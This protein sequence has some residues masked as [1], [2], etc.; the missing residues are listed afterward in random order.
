MIFDF[1]NYTFSGLLSILASLYGVGYPLIM[2]SIGRIYTQYDSTLL[3]NR[4]TKETI[5][6]VFQVLLILNLLFAVST[7]FLLHA[8]WWNIGFVTIQA[9]LLVL[10]MGFTFL[11]FQLMIKYENAGELLRHIEGGQIDKSNIMDIFDLAIY[12]DSKNNHQL[13]ID[14]MSSVFSYITVQQG[15]D[16]KKQNDNEILPPV[17][18]DENVVAILK[19]IKGFIREDD[20]H[21]LL[22]RNNDIVSVLYNQLSKSRISLQAH[23]MMW[24]LLNEA[25][26]YNN[27]SWFKQYW[28]FANSYSSLRYRFVT[29]PILSQDKKEF[30]LRHVMIGTLLL[31]NERYK[32][33]NDIFLY[34]HSEPEYYGLIPSTFIEIVEMLENIDSICTV[35]AFQQQN[36]YFADEMGGVNDEKFVFRKAVKYLSLLVIRL[37][38]L[39]YRNLYNINFLFHIPSSPI[40]IEDA[41]RAATLMD[42]MK[43]DIEEFYSKDIFQLIPRLLPVN[44]ADILY[45]LSDYRDQCLN[46]KETHQNHPDVDCEK[47]SKLKEE[48]MSF[49]NNFNIALPQ[50]NIMAE[51]DNLITKEDVV[52]TKE[53]LETL[54]YS[55]YKNIGLC[56]PPLLT[57]FMFDLYR[58]YLRELHCMEKLSSYE[59]SWSQTQGFLENIGYNDLDYTIITTD[60]IQHLKKTHI[61]LC[62]GVR[63]LGFFILKKSDIPHVSFGEVQRDDLKLIDDSNISSNIDSFVDCHETHFYLVMATKMFVH[64]KEKIDGVIYVSINGGYPEQK[65]PITINATLTE[66]FGN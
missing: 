46:T 22:H 27:H 47:F 20:G 11:L 64:I 33:L 16:F 7:P 43:D 65:K 29:N 39:Q 4:F 5:Y 21:H 30:M 50:N 10:L 13:Y 34:T 48:I 3:A 62:A 24:F 53:R 23:Q 15:D 25:I 54:Y 60:K 6:R 35:P 49:V 38:T 51:V 18:Y 2:Q 41:E 63:P 28:Q 45:L 9:I 26:T 56:K 12:A 42:M 8:E 57:N 55:P 52:E 14:A 31:H 17:V 59:I 1:T 66:L 36:F 32:W 40:L 58:M 61:S 37:W 44:K 19:K